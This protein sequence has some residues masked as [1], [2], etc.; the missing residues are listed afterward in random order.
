MDFLFV[1]VPKTRQGFLTLKGRNSPER[2]LEMQSGDKG[3][4]GK[5]PV[6]LSLQG[7]WGFQAIGVILPGVCRAAL[8]P[9]IQLLCP[10]TCAISRG[11]TAAFLRPFLAHIPANVLS[12]S[13]GS[14][15][16]K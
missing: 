1:N 12:G 3:C 14:V 2:M 16:E 7:L 6:A 15:R 9:Q 10:V 4:R 13:S 5:I 11:L 8:Y